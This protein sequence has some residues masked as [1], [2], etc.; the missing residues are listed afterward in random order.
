M[1]PKKLA[2]LLA[3]F[4]AI[5]ML[6]MLFLHNDFVGIIIIALLLFIGYSCCICD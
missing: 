6:I 3:F 2:G 5:G 4:V 1:E